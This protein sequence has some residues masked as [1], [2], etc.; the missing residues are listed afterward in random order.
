MRKLL[1]RR[2]KPWVSGDNS[3][4][5]SSWKS[6]T[7]RVMRPV[8][9]SSKDGIRN[10][11]LIRWVRTIPLCKSTSTWSDLEKSM[12]SLSKI[13]STR[14][15]VSWSSGKGST[16]SIRGNWKL[17]NCSWGSKKRRRMLRLPYN[18]SYLIWWKIS[19]VDLMKR[20]SKKLWKELRR[21]K[22]RRFIILTAL[23]RVMA[24]KSLSSIIITKDDRNIMN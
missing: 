22:R 10:R 4:P 1:S 7:T 23:E 6:L 9:S 21:E 24:I 17:R 3:Q 19:P 15:L 11:P 16:R 13:T 5:E 8:T 2:S 14:K 12:D 20:L 18:S